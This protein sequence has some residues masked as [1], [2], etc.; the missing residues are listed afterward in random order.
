MNTHDAELLAVAPATAYR[1]YL[2]RPHG[3]FAR[4]ISARFDVV[5]GPGQPIYQPLQDGD[6]LLEVVLGRMRPGRC[7]ILAAG[8]LQLIAL[9]RRLA[10]SQLLLRPRGRGEIADPPLAGPARRTIPRTQ[11]YGMV[12]R[13]RRASVRGYW[14][15]TSPGAAER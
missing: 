5:A 14:P 12:R 1:E 4:W 10:P 6:V 15:S 2:Y 3:E 11:G 7:T 8:D 13:S 9:R